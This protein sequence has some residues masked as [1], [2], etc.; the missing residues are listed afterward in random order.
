[1][2]PLT[3]VLPNSYAFLP[4]PAFVPKRDEVK[5]SGQDYIMRNFKMCTSTS[6]FIR[7]PEAATAV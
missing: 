2:V 5:G 4:D 1:M 7:K 6:R 3:A